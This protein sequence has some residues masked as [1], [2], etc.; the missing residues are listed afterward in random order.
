MPEATIAVIGYVAATL[1]TA[2]FMPQVFQTLKTR[3]TKDISLG[4][5]IAFTT[6]IFLW[7]VYGISLNSPPIYLANGVSFVLAAMILYLKLK[8]G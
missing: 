8:H 7:L 5:Y 2:S 3:R 1:T 4:M 6:G